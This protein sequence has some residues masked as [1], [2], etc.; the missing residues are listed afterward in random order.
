MSSTLTGPV[1]LLQLASKFTRKQV[2]SFWGEEIL[3]PSEMWDHMDMIGEIYVAIGHEKILPYGLIDC[4]SLL[5]HFLTG[6][7]GAGKFLPRRFRSIMGALETRDLGNVAWT[8]GAENPADGLT[9]VKGEIGSLLNL[10]GTGAYRPGTSEHL[11]GV[12]FV[13]ILN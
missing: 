9:K 4:E 3:A 8:P 5:S 7:S 11:W 2:T 10:L 1:H 6:R 12:S 13:G